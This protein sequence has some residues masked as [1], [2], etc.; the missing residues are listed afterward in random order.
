MRENKEE[1][2]G[3]KRRKEPR[4]REDEENE[5]EEAEEA[6]QR[7]L[8]WAHPS[9]LFWPGQARGGGLWKKKCYC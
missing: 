3:E 7:F 2:R 1:L 4:R 5:E 9:L 6:G 8:R